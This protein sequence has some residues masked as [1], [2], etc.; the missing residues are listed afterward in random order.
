[1]EL[2]IRAQC[3]GGISLAAPI[4]VLLCI[5]WEHIAGE[6]KRQGSGNAKFADK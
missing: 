5:N 1:M 4:R 2:A 6:K 3:I